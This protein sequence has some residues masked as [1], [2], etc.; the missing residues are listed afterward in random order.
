MAND[1]EFLQ[2]LRLKVVRARVEVGSNSEVRQYLGEFRL[3][4]TDAVFLRPQFLR[5]RGLIDRTLGDEEM[6]QDLQRRS[7][8]AVEKFGDGQGFALS[9]LDGARL[10]LERVESLVVPPKSGPLIE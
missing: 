5:I 1:D 6:A 3:H 10:L 7:A 2:S 9:T 4:P 8:S